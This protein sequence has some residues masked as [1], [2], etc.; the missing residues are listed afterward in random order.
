MIFGKL[1]KSIGNIRKLEDL[2]FQR[3]PTQFLMTSLL[4]KIHH[5]VRT[6]FLFICFINKK[7]KRL[8]K[9]HT[10]GTLLPA[11]GITALNHWGF[12]VS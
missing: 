10:H 1:I 8:N 6:C 2:N 11:F 4:N 7:K 3:P 9:T 5:D 12:P